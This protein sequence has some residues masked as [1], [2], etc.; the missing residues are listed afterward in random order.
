[1]PIDVGGDG[2]ISDGFTCG[3]HPQLRIQHD[4]WRRVD[5]HQISAN[6]VS[7]LIHV[8]EVVIHV[9]IDRRSIAP[10]H[11]NPLGPDHVVWSERTSS[12]QRDE[13]GPGYEIRHLRL[14]V[15]SHDHRPTGMARHSGPEAGE[16]LE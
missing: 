7:V 11:G 12:G 4:P 1:M 5:G 15:A 10:D 2:R 3:Q 14:R 6:P 16:V 9:G 13:V 8:A